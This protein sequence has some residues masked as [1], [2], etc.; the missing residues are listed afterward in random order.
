MDVIGGKNKDIVWKI[1]LYCF[2]LLNVI[3][4]YILYFVFWKFFFSENLSYW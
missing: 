3:Y 2:M 4:K 1:I